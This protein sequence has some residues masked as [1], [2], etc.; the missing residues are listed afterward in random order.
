MGASPPPT[1]F[2]VSRPLPYDNDRLTLN[3]PAVVSAT[4]PN[5]RQQPNQPYR[6]G[7]VTALRLEDDECF[8]QGELVEPEDFW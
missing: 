3:G 1:L 7:P 6:N 8:A 2:P 4:L 5:R